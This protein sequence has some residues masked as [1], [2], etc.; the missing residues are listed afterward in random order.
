MR[1]S[2]RPASRLI[3]YLNDPIAVRGPGDLLRQKRAVERVAAALGG[4]IEVLCIDS[5]RRFAGQR[6]GDAV[7]RLIAD[8][9]RGDTVLVEEMACLAAD[10]EAVAVVA[11][12]MAMLGAAVVASRGLADTIEVEPS[13]VRSTQILRR[14][15][16]VAKPALEACA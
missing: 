5:G 4:G 12:T 11:G 15:V 14:P 8:L 16:N 2:T 10:E 7:L 6:C 13:T 9:R 1:P 3:A